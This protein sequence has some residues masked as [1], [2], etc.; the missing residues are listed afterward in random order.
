MVKTKLG[1]KKAKEIALDMIK[2]GNLTR[3]LHIAAFEKFTQS[4]HE[5]DHRIA[6]A[7]LKYFI[8]NYPDDFDHEITLDKLIEYGNKLARSTW[9]V[10][11]REVLY[12]IITVRNLPAVWI[13]RI[14]DEEPVH[15]RLAF[16]K[17]L[18]HM[19]T[20]KQI[21]LDRTLGFLQYFIDD[22]DSEVRDQLVQ[23]FAEIGKR[24]CERVHYFLKEQENGAGSHRRALIH[25]A[26][27]K[28]GLDT[29]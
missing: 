1:W 12:P 20:R 9:S 27:V 26:R 11:G 18:K 2:D 6:I 23:V 28:L 3:E 25:A 7:L 5:Q 13:D 8:S 24:D 14:A 22:P 4:R 21:P 16:A 10:F 17:A 15:L 29:C 19:A